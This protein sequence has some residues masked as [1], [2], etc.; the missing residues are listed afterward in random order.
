MIRRIIYEPNARTFTDDQNEFRELAKSYQS[1]RA[2]A[3]Q[4]NEAKDKALV[5]LIAAAERA[6]KWTQA[7][8]YRQ[9]LLELRRRY[10]GRESLK[11]LEVL[12]TI[13]DQKLYRYDAEETWEFWPH[14][15]HPFLT[16]AEAYEN[17]RGKDNPRSLLARLRYSIRTTTPDEQFQ[18]YKNNSNK[19]D[20]ETHLV[21]LGYL[22][23]SGILGNKLRPVLSDLILGLFQDLKA[24]PDRSIELIYMI[25]AT[26]EVFFNQR[27]LLRT[28]YDDAHQI[29]LRHFGEAHPQICLWLSNMLDYELEHGDYGQGAIYAK[30]GAEIWLSFNEELKAAYFFHRQGRMESRNNEPRRA[31]NS[32]VKVFH[33]GD[34]SLHS[35]AIYE[36]ERIAAH[37]KGY[38]VRYLFQDPLSSHIAKEALSKLGKYLDVL[39]TATELEKTNHTRF[40]NFIAYLKPLAELDGGENIFRARLRDAVKADD[41]ASR[42]QSLND[43]CDC[44][45]AKEDYNSIKDLLHD[46]IA[47]RAIPGDIEN[48]SDTLALQ[49]KLIQRGTPDIVEAT[50]KFAVRFLEKMRVLSPKDLNYICRLIRVINQLI[51][52]K[53]LTYA[54]DLIEQVR[55][56]AESLNGN[57]KIKNR[58][59]Q[60]LDSFDYCFKE[61][62]EQ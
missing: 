58:V 14:E 13:C 21:V 20:P 27:R 45:L 24:P 10:L 34:A 38:R 53:Q 2:S 25:G 54:C 51:A 46:E 55:G 28:L 56:I 47:R 41:S 59:L 6:F 7:N 33:Y 19:L 11:T 9:E 17:N 61:T 40:A 1:L 39:P 42:Q 31:I 12:E 26:Y 23:D 36:L 44:L 37:P 49:E 3:D 22:D 43:L 4:N 29:T 57:H 8:Q 18:W 35:Y 15:Q 52:R 50:Y 30:R 62:P 32:F 48:C 60:Q 16:I 5:E